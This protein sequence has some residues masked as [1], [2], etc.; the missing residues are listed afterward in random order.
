[1]DKEELIELWLKAEEELRNG[2]DDRCIEFK[3][4]FSE[5]Y[6]NLNK[7]EQEYVQEYLDSCGA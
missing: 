1:M 5:H 4:S 6:A 7:N 2:N 3:D